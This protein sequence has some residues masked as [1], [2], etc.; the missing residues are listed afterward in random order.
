M[1]EKMS[2]S[3]ENLLGFRIAGTVSQE[4]YETVLIPALEA[5]IEEHERLRLLVRVESDFKDYTL[6]ALFE[7]MRVGLKH[8]RGFD[9]V[10]L[11]AETKWVVRAV[12]A[13]SIFMPC[14]VAVFDL[15]EQDEAHRWL[16]E[17]LGA[18]HQTDLGGGVLHVQLMGKLDAAVYDEEEQDLD[19]FIR[20]NDGFKLLLDL[21]EFDG[22]QGLAALGEHL[23]LVR[24]H[25]SL[26]DRMAI[27]GSARYIKLGERLASKFI[28]AKVK[29]FDDDEL[30]AAKEW[31]AKG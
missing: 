23:S 16:T 18:I 13:F 2:L 20:A 31:I 25:R 5:A 10:A 29:Q 15:S 1:I 28:N 3:H 30:D 24:D 11:V 4:D 27:V 14:P 6:G 22:W 21:R 8:W 17:S 26:V 12:K 7:D 19:A 9:R